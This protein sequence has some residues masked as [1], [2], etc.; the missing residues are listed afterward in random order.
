MLRAPVIN[1]QWFAD[2]AETPVEND[3]LY[4]LSWQA[5]EAAGGFSVNKYKVEINGTEVG[6]TTELYYDIIP[7]D[8][9][10]D[11]VTVKITGMN[12]DNVVSSAAEK[13]VNILLINLY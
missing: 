11:I 7:S 4:R 13:N 1:I 8:Y 12:D 9:T 10:S 6:T 2:N 3:E 5:I